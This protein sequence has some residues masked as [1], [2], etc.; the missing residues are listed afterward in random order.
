MSPTKEKIMDILK[1]DIVS[2]S[3]PQKRQK[4]NELEPINLNP[5]AKT[6]ADITPKKSMT[7]EELEKFSLWMN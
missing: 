4:L 2:H 5:G 1:K 6:S 7:K 3:T